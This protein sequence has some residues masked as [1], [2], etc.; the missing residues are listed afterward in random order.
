MISSEVQRT[1]VKSPPELWA[2]LSDPASLSR[3][4]GEFGEIRITRVEPES[5][6]EWEADSA[7]GSV[8]IKPSGWG[9]RVILRARREIPQAPSAADPEPMAEPEPVAEPDPPAA[10]MTDGAAEP[11][12]PSEPEAPAELAQAEQPQVE[13]TAGLAEWSE[14]ACEHQPELKSQPE[15][16]PEPQ[17]RRGL[18]ARLLGWRL[19]RTASEPLRSMVED[20]LQQPAESQDPIP[21]VPAPLVW[22]ASGTELQAP[23]QL[24]APATDELEAPE[25]DEQVAPQPEAPVPAAA[26]AHPEGQMQERQQ[27]AETSEQ[28]AD[29]AAELPATEEMAEE[30]VTAVL[31]AMLDR[32]GTAHH[33]PFSRS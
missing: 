16:E 3:H 27:P 7:A 20:D 30:D 18:I 31:S 23:E 6:V 2:E 8:S 22:A 1:L 5:T 25:P 26:E 4:L 19:R 9:T 14:Q 29:I 33:R 15:P 13:P 32:L 28:A 12:P 24:E 17:P 10:P 11:G 21:D